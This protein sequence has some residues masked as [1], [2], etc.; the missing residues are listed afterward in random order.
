MVHEPL[1]PAPR[2][3]PR[4]SVLTPVPLQTAE[5][6]APTAGLAAAGSSVWVGPP[7]LASEPSWGFLPMMSVAAGEPQFVLSMRLY[8]PDVSDP[9]PV[10]RQF[11]AAPPEAE[12]L[13]TMLS[14]KVSFEASMV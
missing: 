9:V 3:T 6:I 11:V 1:A 8:P 4:W 5:G 13:A 7:L 12:P 10:T 14:A 2:A